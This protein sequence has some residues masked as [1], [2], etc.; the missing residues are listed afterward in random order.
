MDPSVLRLHV[1]FIQQKR[2]AGVGNELYK[3]ITFDLDNIYSNA[4]R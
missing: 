4:F 3:V 1:I 2:D